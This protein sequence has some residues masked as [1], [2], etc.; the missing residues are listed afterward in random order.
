MPLFA[1]PTHGQLAGSLYLAATL[2]C[3]VI[4]SSLIIEQA[5]P[6]HGES[7]LTLNH[8]GSLYIRIKWGR[9]L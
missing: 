3:R 1:T 7:V 2:S 5:R 4:L 8:T 6:G 9:T